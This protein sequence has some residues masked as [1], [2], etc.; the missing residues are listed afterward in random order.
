[1]A[2]LLLF[3]QSC[4][5]GN[6]P[7]QKSTNESV[8]PGGRTAPPLTLKGLEGIPDDKAKL[9]QEML[10]LAAAQRDVAVVEGA[11]PDSLWLSGVFRIQKNT[12]GTAVSYQWRLDDGAGKSV[13]SFSG[14]EQA[15]ATS[16]DPWGAVFPD[17]LRRI[18]AATTENLASRLAQMGYA[19]RTAG[20]PPPALSFRLASAK[21]GSEIDLETMYGPLGL[22]AENG[23]ETAEPRAEPKVSSPAAKAGTAKP[24]RRSEEIRAIALTS[25]TGS[26][27]DGDAELRKA[28]KEALLSAGWPV[29]D[30]PRGDALTVTGRVNVDA[31]KGDR[32]TV[33]LAWNVRAPSGRDLGT[34]R[35]SNAVS[36][37]SLANG[38]AET[39]TEVAEAAALGLFDLVGKLR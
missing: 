9:F 7:F 12:A 22:P 15:G 27:A 31:P 24:T 4:S 37:G 35:Q 13:H 14:V 25:V 21:D 10:A 34:V 17:V 19:T 8:S 1:V 2:L 6:Q 32:Q 16:G 20:L 18:A 39:A 28:L 29:L 11:F 36:A 33:V 23:A 5:A 30:A 26:P 38:W 3:L